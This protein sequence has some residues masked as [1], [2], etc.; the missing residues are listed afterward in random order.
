LGLSFLW[1][2]VGLDV[3]R[4]QPGRCQGED[5]G[6]DLGQ[7]VFASEQDLAVVGVVP[8]EGAGRQTGA[9]GDLRN[10]RIDEPTFGDELHRPPRSRC[11][12][13]GAHPAMSAEPTG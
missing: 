5:P 6:D 9:G 4:G 10:G 2:G 11:A 13:S 3:D 7:L 1:S 8:E 12:A